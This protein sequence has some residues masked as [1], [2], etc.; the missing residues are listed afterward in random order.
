[1]TS[2]PALSDADDIFASRFDPARVG[3]NQFHDPADIM[4]FMHI[5]KTAGMSV[6]K[7]L[8]EGFDVFHPVS[9]EQTARSFRHKSRAALYAR[10][11]GQPRRQVLMGHFGWPEVM[12]WKT[13]ELPVKCA[14]IIRDPLA[15]FVSNYRYNCSERHPQHAQFRD[16]FPTM[17]SY[18]QDLS[19]D[20]QLTLMTGAFYSF[21][22]A[23]EKLARHYS[24]IGLTEHLG[25]SLAHFNRSHGLPKLVEHRENTASERPRKEAAEIPDAVVNLVGEKS[26]NDQ[27]LHDLLSRF[28]G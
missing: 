2:S 4:L 16:R 28:Y 27:R 9:W 26:R 10:T 18:A 13:H 17:E 23:L 19:N 11:D 20:Y 22:Q 15:R 24:F 1:M 12:F 7:A 3:K 6:G 5:P 25:A 14:T 21:E 8:Q